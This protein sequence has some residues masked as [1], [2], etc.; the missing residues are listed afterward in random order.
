[1]STQ[2][3]I[4]DNTSPQGGYQ[5]STLPV[6]ASAATPG[7]APASGADPASGAAPAPGVDPAAGPDPR[8]DP[9]PGAAPGPDPDAED[10]VARI[11]AKFGKPS[12]TISLVLTGALGGYIMVLTLA[13]ALQA[14]LTSILDGTTATAI[15]SR[16]T[17]L[18][19]LL[20]L[21]MIPLIGGLSD[22]TTSRLGRRRPW[23][24]I[25]YLVA[26]ACFFL[27]GALDNSAVITV[28][29]I[30]GITFAQAGFNAYS[31]IPVEGVP[32]RMRGSVM[33]FMGL[34]GALAMP[35]GSYMAAA[36]V[37]HPVL[38]MTAPVVLGIVFIIPLLLLYKDPQHTKEEIPQG[39]LLSIFSN[40]FVNP[41][42]H[43]NFGW[44]WLARFLAG[45]AMT[46]FLAFSF[47]YLV[48][49][50]GYSA[51]E[52]ARISGRISLMTAPVSIICFTGSGWLSDRLGVRKP[53]VAAAA[54]LMAV[55]LILAGTSQTLTVFTIA[56]MVFAVGQATYLTVDLAL[57]SAVL[58]S[59]ADA[60]KAWRSSA[61]PSICPASLSRPSPPPSWG[62]P[63]TTTPSCGVWPRPAALSA[64]SSCP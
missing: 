62:L 35:I 40:F 41:L 51:G 22:R 42:K 30:V 10:D 15:Y 48:V 19:A 8:V 49:G 60:G 17:S 29:Y 7:A 33:G 58:P 13:T 31:V 23:I 26:L 16:T 34:C 64:P 43:P 61:W 45:I 12:R 1:M 24:I 46:S 20:M 11:T 14:R 25:G 55:A 3:Q 54:I 63:R 44:V 28:A 56:M 39:G 37:K 50:L 21:A 4:A 18:A 27:I 6:D 38:L 57:C 52:T 9:D 32:N 5:L 53:F 47:L 59:Q 36:L 2:P